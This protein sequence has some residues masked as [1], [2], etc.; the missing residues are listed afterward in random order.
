[1]VSERSGIISRDDDEKYRGIV[2]RSRCN[3]RSRDH[4][5]ERPGCAFDGG[6]LVAARELDARTA[7]LVR[8]QR[9]ARTRTF[10]RAE[11]GRHS[12]VRD[13]LAHA[14]RFFVH[15]NVPAGRLPARPRRGRGEPLLG[16]RFARN[17]ELRDCRVASVSA[18][19]GEPARA[20]LATD[21]HRGDSRTIVVRRGR[22]LVIR[23][24][25]RSARLKP[26]SFRSRG[27][28]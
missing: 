9:L 1:M 15:T 18:T 6:E 17:T 2:R 28:N 24:P 10:G 13:V 22:R 21:G 4:R 27:V 11:G 16:T 26:G 19:S 23:A 8:A 12:S 3:D 5:T 7:R 14:L 20:V 25:I